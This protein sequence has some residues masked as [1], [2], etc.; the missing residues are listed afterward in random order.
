MNQNLNDGKRVKSQIKKVILIVVIVFTIIVSSILLIGAFGNPLENF[1]LGPL[2]EDENINEI[3]IDEIIQQG[4]VEFNITKLEIGDKYSVLY[5]DM[6]PFISG[7]MLKGAKLYQNGLLL[8]YISAVASTSRGCAIAF[9]PASDTDGLELKIDTIVDVKENVYIYPLEFQNN[10]VILQAEVGDEIG[11]ITITLLED[12]CEIASQGLAQLE[13]KEQFGGPS[14]PI[15]YILLTDSVEN[16]T[17]YCM[18]KAPTHLK[19]LTREPIYGD[20][21]II[22]PIS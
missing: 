18:G 15:E 22:I 9:E 11:N 21:T 6:T 17:G 20:E 5:F 3:T 7:N 4:S 16:D 14:N 19:I 10:V 12:G 13:S 1:I 8:S 2:F